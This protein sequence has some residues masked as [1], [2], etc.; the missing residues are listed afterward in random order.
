MKEIFT[1]K[2]IPVVPSL[3]KIFVTQVSLTCLTKDRRISADRQ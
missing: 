2:G 1:N 3:G